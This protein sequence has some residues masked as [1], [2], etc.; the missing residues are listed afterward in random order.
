MTSGFVKVMFLLIR[1]VPVC[2]F[3]V[4][5]YVLTEM[6]VQFAARRAFMI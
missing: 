6:H 5:E 4:V 1:K 2:F 3:T